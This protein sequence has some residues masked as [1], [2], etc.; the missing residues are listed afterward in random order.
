MPYSTISTIMNK[1]IQGTS[2]NKIITIC[3]ALGISTDDLAEGRIVPLNRNITTTK[4]EDLIDDLKHKLMNT[5]NL[6]IDD[7]PATDEELQ[8][9]INALEISLEIG[10]RNMKEKDELK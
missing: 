6:T 10:K 1:G 7:K 8:A 9:V 2:V 4:V 3:Q 5:E